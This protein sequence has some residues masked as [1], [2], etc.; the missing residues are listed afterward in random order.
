MQN[1]FTEWYYK[2]KN[3]TIKKEKGSFC[4][5]LNAHDTVTESY[6]THNVA[7]YTL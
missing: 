3:D 2:T 1:Y 4:L 5:I 7:K 6:I